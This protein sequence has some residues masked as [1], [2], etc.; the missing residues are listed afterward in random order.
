MGKYLLSG[1]T[2]ESYINGLK[3]ILRLFVTSNKLYNYWTNFILSSIFI[4]A[5]SVSCIANPG[6]QFHL[7]ALDGNE[8]KVLNQTF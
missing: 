5:V 4:P 8:L 6:L 3:T 2:V 7:D 1:K